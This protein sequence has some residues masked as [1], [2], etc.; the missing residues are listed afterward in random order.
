MDDKLPNGVIL[1]DAVIL[2]TCV[3][4]KQKMEY[5]IFKYSYK[6]LCMLSR[7]WGIAYYISIQVEKNNL[8]FF[9]W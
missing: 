8:T 4:K 6:K 7:K 9:V 3:I 1:K 2:I 5:F